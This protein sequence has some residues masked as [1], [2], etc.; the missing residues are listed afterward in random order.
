MKEKEFREWLTK[1]YA[2]KHVISS[3]VSNVV[4]INEVYNVDLYYEE[5][6]EYDL[7]ELFQY[8]KEDESL[9]LEPKAD[10][11]INGSYYKGFST[12]RQA[13]NL[14]FAFLDSTKL[15]VKNPNKNQSGYSPKFIGNIADFTSYVGPKCRNIVN[16]IAKN[17]RMKCNG[18]CEYCGK[19]AELQSAHKQGE[20]RPQIIE[21]ILNK[22]YKIGNDLYDVP[23]NDFMDYF[24]KA[25]LPIRNHIYFLCPKCHNAYDK[26][27][28]ITDDMINAKRILN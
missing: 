13:L 19:Q 8:S 18:I 10:I 2:D 21:K 4:R 25:H 9:G 20:E 26:K 3:R 15:V 11:Q 23:L 22:H 28:T 5:D 17:D 12:L 16:T 6:N 1:K 27:K 7:L 24:K 14:Y